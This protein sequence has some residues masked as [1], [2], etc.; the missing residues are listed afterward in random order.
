MHKLLLQG[1]GGGS[2][3][4]GTCP[5]SDAVLILATTL[6]LITI[7]VLSCLCILSS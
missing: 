2:K 7:R 3:V 5:Y 6:Q 4:V 1:L